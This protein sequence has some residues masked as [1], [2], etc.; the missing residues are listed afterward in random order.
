M[1]SFLVRDVFDQS[2]FKLLIEIRPG[3][4]KIQIVKESIQIQPWWLGAGGRAVDL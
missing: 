3:G 2:H 1:V 4:I